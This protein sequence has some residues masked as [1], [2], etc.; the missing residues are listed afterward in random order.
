MKKSLVKLSAFILLS[1]IIMSPISVHAS[2]I[3][4]ES[5]VSESSASY[6]RSFLLQNDENR[7]LA[8]DSLNFNSHWNSAEFLNANECFNL[9][10]K[11]DGDLIFSSLKANPGLML[12]IVN[13]DISSHLFKNT[14]VPASNDSP[15]LIYQITS[16]KSSYPLLW[17][18][19]AI[20]GTVY[21]T[22]DYSGAAIYELKDNA[23]INTYSNNNKCLLW[24]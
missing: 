13:V 20:T 15:V 2:E 9:L 1:S 6:L 5:T 21:S 7:K 16:E 24:R 11:E 22:Q 10:I 19:D 4:Q 3:S 23:V 8:A 14:S 17:I 12:T 18:V